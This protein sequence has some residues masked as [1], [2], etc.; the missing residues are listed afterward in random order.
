MSHVT[1]QRRIEPVASD[2]VP[3]ATTPSAAG[4][5]CEP[6]QLETFLPYRLNVLATMVSQALARVY[7]ARFGISIPE[8]RVLATLGQ[9]G[10]ITAREVGRHSHMHK[11]TVSRAVAALEKRNLVV[12]RSNQA[13][14]REAFLAMTPHGL[15]IYADI[16]PLARAFNDELCASLSGGDRAALDEFIT[17]LT[18]RMGDVREPD[19]TF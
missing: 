1:A 10:E 7:G 12:R 17:R 15:A 11:T 8:W 18:A 13:D 19:S 5:P 16:V 3:E 6:I 9:F 4:P 14:M 2:P